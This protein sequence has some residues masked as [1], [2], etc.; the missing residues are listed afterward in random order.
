MR[1][2]VESA[3]LAQNSDWP[4]NVRALRGGFYNDYWDE[5]DTGVVQRRPDWEGGHP[6]ITDFTW[7][8]FLETDLI[9]VP[10]HVG[11]TRETRLQLSAQGDLPRDS[12]HWFLVTIEPKL[13]RIAYYDSLG[14]TRA[15]DRLNTFRDFLLNWERRHLGIPE[16]D[17]FVPM[18][19]WDLENM[20]SPRQRDG[21][22]CGCFTISNA[23]Y[24]RRGLYPTYENTNDMRTQ[25]GIFPVIIILVIYL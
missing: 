15:N 5:T 9:L 25:I 13:K 24:L 4:R 6:M 11:L 22:D 10:S 1:L 17:T 8:E 23:E 20:P 16:T 12:G 21:F 18:L 7:E 3:P 14:F 19:Q 2:I